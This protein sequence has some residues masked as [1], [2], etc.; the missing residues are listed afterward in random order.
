MKSMDP[1]PGSACVHAREGGHI[2]RVG[3]GQGI[4]FIPL[5]PL[6]WLDLLPGN[7]LPA[8]HERAQVQLQLAVDAIDTFVVPRMPLHVAQMQEA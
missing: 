3:H 5:Q 1:L 8:N 2:W 7:G 4:G 6:A